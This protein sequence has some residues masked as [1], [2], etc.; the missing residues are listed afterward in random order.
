[1]SKSFIDEKD[2][3]GQLKIL[4]SPLKSRF[5]KLSFTALL[6]LISLFFLPRQGRMN[7]QDNLED[8]TASN[9]SVPAGK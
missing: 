3:S 5:L 7:S 4:A 2:F 1:M 9:Y 8:D 6:T